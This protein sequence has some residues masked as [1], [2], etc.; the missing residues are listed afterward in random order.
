MLTVFSDPECKAAAD[1]LQ[2]QCQTDDERFNVAKVCWPI[3]G[4]PS[5]Q[6]CFTSHADNPT[7]IFRVSVYSVQGWLAGWLHGV[8]VLGVCVGWS[9][10]WVCL[11]VCVG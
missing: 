3:L 11:C 5:H 4:K 9:W 8:C 1:S 6:R 10:C 2:N 7:A